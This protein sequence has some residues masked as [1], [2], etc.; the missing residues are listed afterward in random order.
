MVQAG[1]EDLTTNSVAS[2]PGR[3]RLQYAETEGEGLGE[4]VTCMMSG[5]CEGRHEGGSARQR[6]LRS[7]L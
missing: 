1:D 7:F 5:R 2:F 4:K 6:I 3:F